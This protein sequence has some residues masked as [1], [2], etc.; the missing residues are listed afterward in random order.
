[1]KLIFERSVPGR[2]TAYLPEAPRTDLG[3]P[4]REKPPRLPELSESQVDRHYTELAK[5]TRGVN[6][7]FYPLG[8][9]T[10]QYNP[11]VLATAANQPGS[12]T[13]IRC[14]RMRAY[15]AAWRLCSWRSGIFVRLP[16]WT[17]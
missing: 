5:E 17:P 14:S 3:F 4:L 16:V 2:S 9:C 7:G 15:R 12:R 1:M 13:C 8:S 11:A 6:G 10:M